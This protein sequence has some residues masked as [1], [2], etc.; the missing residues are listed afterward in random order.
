MALVMGFLNREAVRWTLKAV[1]QGDAESQHHLGSLYYQ[2]GDTED[3]DEAVRWTRK[4]ADQGQ[5]GAQLNL[6]VMYG[7]GQGVPVNL[8]EMTRWTQKA[9]NQG[10]AGAQRML[11]VLSKE[12]ITPET[13]VIRL[14]ACCGRGC[15]AGLKLKPCSRCKSVLYCGARRMP[16]GTLEGGAQS[17]LLPTKP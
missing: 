15:E 9:A 12:G 3:L 14:C 1:E 10:H 2:E 7:T 6:G 13:P 8:I 4:A 17:K 11:A 5:A 16:T